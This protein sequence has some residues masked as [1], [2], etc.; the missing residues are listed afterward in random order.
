MFTILQKGASVKALRLLF[1][2]KNKA[3]KK[4][5][6]PLTYVDNEDDNEKNLN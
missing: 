2:V 5:V 3:N 6:S 1:A 4:A